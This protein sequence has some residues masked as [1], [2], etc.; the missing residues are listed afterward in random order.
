MG[1]VVGYHGCFE[2]VK[3]QTNRRGTGYNGHYRYDWP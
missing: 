1:G 3:K 2:I